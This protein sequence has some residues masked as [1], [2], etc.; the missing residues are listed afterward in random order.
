MQSEGT[1]VHHQRARC[2]PIQEQST[3]VEECVGT[4]E[5]REA[6]RA[7]P[8]GPRQRRL[9]KPPEVPTSRDD[10]NRST[11]RRCQVAVGP[12]RPLQRLAISLRVE[13]KHNCHGHLQPALP[14]IT[15]ENRP[16]SA[17]NR[18]PLTSL[19]THTIWR[20]EES[21]ARCSPSLVE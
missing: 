13:V 10:Q 15:A 21:Q 12:G 1:L 11:G 16:W 19:S 9:S 17:M 5:G 7:R 2:L 20:G 18:T 14:K 4:M 6:S 8:P 3:I